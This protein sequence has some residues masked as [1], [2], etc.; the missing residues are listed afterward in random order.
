MKSVDQRS[1]S[2]SQLHR[3]LDINVVIRFPEQI[4]DPNIRLFIFTLFHPCQNSLGQNGTSSEQR[5]SEFHPNA[6]CSGLI[7]PV[8]SFGSLAVAYC[9]VLFTYLYL[10][11]TKPAYNDGRTFTPII[12]AISFLIGLQMCQI[13]LNPLASIADTI[14][15]CLEQTFDLSFIASFEKFLLS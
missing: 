9:C 12:M 10:E 5:D 15:V 1:E 3:S 8:L 13:L 6:G 11:F 7:G 4:S 14:F 2:P